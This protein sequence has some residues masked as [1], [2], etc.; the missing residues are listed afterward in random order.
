M[1]E[2]ETVKLLVLDNMKHAI[3]MS[4]PIEVEMSTGEN[5][6]EAH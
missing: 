5:W 2:I 3:D 6:L 1:N 4:I